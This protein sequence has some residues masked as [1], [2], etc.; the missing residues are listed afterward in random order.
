MNITDSIR[1]HAQE[2]PQSTAVIRVASAV[3]YRDLDRIIDLLAA[4]LADLGLRPGDVAGVAVASRFGRLALNLALAR[5]GAAAATVQDGERLEGVTLKTCFVDGDA[6]PAAGSVKVDHAWW[7]TPPDTQRMPSV[8]VHPGGTATCII[9][10]S[11]GTTGVSKAIALNHDMVARRVQARSRALRLPANQRQLC[12][13]GTGLNYGF[14]SVLQPLWSGGLV[15]LAISGAVHAAIQLYQLNWLVMSPSQLYGILAAMPEGAGPYPSLE[16]LE[17]G[18]S[19]LSARLAGQARERLCANLWIAYGAAESGNVAAGQLASLE[20]HAGGAGFLAPGVEVQAVDEHDQP[21]PAGSEGAIRIRS[22]YCAT[23]YLGDAEASAKSFRGGWFYP[24]DTG[25]VSAEG[26]LCVTG[27][28]DE[29][30][31]AGGVKVSPQLIED[32]VL[33]NPDIQE[34]AAFSTA[35]PVSGMTEIW[36]AIVASKPVDGEAL[37]ALCRERL[38]RANAPQFIL[39]VKEL[40]RNENGKVQRTRLVKDAAAVMARIAREKKDAPPSVH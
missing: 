21:L 5:M 2:S 3:T 33:L 20:G 13:L 34:A 23:S 15:T 10:R 39:Q 25:S 4:R 27:R 11:S 28:T 22:D 30:I 18:G 29:R 31:N 35:N 40:P 36:V 7:R 9:V 6:T 17:I 24:G 19:I 16:V 14:T 8:P 12:M 32:A 38:G 37:R 1:R 26:L